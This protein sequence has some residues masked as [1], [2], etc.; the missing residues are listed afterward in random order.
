MRFFAKTN[1]GKV[2]KTQKGLKSIDI[3]FY[4]FSAC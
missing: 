4:S 2:V 3:P 1:Q